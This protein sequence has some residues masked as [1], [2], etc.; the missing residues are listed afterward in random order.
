M[1]SSLRSGR[2]LVASLG[3]AAILVTG[4]TSKVVGHANAQSDSTSPTTP[5]TTSSSSSQPPATDPA[6]DNPQAV[7]A[8][9]AAARRE[10]AI[11]N[12]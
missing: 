9:D 4:C 11:I 8:T 10:M 3:L 6:F 2:C 7:A 12:S 1:T 5:P